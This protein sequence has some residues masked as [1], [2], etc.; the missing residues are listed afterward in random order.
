MNYSI[1]DGDKP[2]TGILFVAPIFESEDLTNTFFNQSS[3]FHQD[4]DTT[5]NLGLGFRR[6]AFDQLALLGAK[7]VL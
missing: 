6:L 3:I 4:G 1:A 5:V 7:H 2:L